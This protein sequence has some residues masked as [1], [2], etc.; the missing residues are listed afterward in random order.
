MELNNATK[1]T[2]DTVPLETDDLD[3]QIE[4]DDLEQ[5][6]Q[7]DLNSIY[8]VISYKPYYLL[9]IATFLSSWVSAL[10]VNFAFSCFC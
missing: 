7:Q 1:N 6:R 8:S 2:R 5:R 4:D 9:Y 10:S 3:K